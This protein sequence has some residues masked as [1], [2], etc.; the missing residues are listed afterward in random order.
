ML[1]RANLEA[2]MLAD[3]FD[4]EVSENSNSGFAAFR[5]EQAYD[6][7]RRAITEELAKRFL[8]IRNAVL[9]YQANKVH[10]GVRRQRG[11]GEVRISGN[12]VFRL[13]MKVGEVAAAAARNQNLFAD[14]SGPLEHGN[15]P[16]PL[17]CLNGAHEASR[18]TTQNDDI[19]FVF[20]D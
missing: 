1:R 11:F 14:A 16:S 13:A 3:A 17:P 6:L 20:H 18:S 10:G 19:K 15:T 4:Y 12:E 8:V 5:L 9:F 2:R 7:L